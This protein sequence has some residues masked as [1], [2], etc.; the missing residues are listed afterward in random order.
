MHQGTSPKSRGRGLGTHPLPFMLL[1]HDLTPQRLH[2]LPLLRELSFNF[3][4]SGLARLEAI[5]RPHRR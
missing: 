2:E 4:D 5:P 1:L 3:F